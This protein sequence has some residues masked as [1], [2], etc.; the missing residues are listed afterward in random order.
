MQG[1]TATTAP[2]ILAG[3]WWRSP[4]RLAPCSLSSL[5]LS[6]PATPRVVLSTT[7]TPTLAGPTGGVTESPTASQGGTV[8]RQPPGRRGGKPRTV[9]GPGSEP[10]CCS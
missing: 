10:A 6:S 4:S 3:R 1:A 9:P 5:G 7:S 2:V 8:L